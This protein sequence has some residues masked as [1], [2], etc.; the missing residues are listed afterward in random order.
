MLSRLACN[1]PCLV[2]IGFF[3][4]ASCYLVHLGAPLKVVDDGPYYLD[5]EIDIA[6][7]LGYHDAHL[8]RGYPQA[9]A[10]LDAT[11]SP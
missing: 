10:A 5:S 6:S 4:I 3:F 11:R 7:G 2:V 9:L 1:V 8:P